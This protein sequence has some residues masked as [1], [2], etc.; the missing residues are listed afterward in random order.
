MQGQKSP[1]QE[2]IE[3]KKAQIA[4]E[5]SSFAVDKLFLANGWNSPG[6]VG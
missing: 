3:S 5:L 2:D 1:P 6:D 4:A